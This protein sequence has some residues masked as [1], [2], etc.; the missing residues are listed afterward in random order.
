MG[1]YMHACMHAWVYM[2]MPLVSQLKRVP[3]INDLYCFTILNFCSYIVQAS[4]VMF[5]TDGN[6]RFYS[7]LYITMITM[8][9]HR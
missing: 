9:L 1:T 7:Y 3:A 2:C 4:N 6:V 5:S 8:L